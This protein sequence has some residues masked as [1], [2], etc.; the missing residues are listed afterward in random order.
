[1][2]AGPGRLGGAKAVGAG[3]GAPTETLGLS[4]GGLEAPVKGGKKKEEREKEG[5][6]QLDSLCIT[7]K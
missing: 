7:N 4:R 1:M 6:G 5:E 2:R 3:F